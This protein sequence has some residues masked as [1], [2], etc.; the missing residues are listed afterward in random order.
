MPNENHTIQ[1]QIVTRPIL[2][3]PNPTVDQWVGPFSKQRNLAR[4]TAYVAPHLF[5]CPLDFPEVSSVDKWF[6]PLSEPKRFK[7]A[8]ET[9]NH[10]ALFWVQATF[11]EE[12]YYSKFNYPW[13]EPVR[14][15]RDPQE[16]SALIASGCYYAVEP[17]AE[18]VQL[19]WFSPLSEPVRIKP[20]LKA[21]LQQVEA[22][23]NLSFYTQTPKYHGYIII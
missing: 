6:R 17:L 23:V 12:I 19:K 10:P 15:K 22:Y 20:G 5:Y 16:V 9:S 2:P 1:Y 21:C 3:L 18:A 11:G 14:L 4:S 13:S 7:P 8:L